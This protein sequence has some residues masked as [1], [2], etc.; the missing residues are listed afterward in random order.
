MIT[1][2][3]A[4]AMIGATL[5]RLNSSG[6]V[7]ASLDD[8]LLALRRIQEERVREAFQNLFNRMTPNELATVDAA[9]A[10]LYPPAPSPRPTTSVTSSFVAESGSKKGR[11][12]K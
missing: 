12:K 2:A 3:E 9:L 4:K 1:T 7:L 8:A 11:P 6:R 10:E 5:D